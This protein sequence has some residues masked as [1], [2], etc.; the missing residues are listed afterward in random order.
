M[1]LD[2]YA[3]RRQFDRAWRPA[4]AIGHDLHRHAPVKEAARGS[5]HIEQLTR[6]RR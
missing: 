2:D 5:K 4:M 6:R 3:V 1:R